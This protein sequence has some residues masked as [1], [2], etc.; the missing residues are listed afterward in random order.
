LPGLGEL[1]SRKIDSTAA[2]HQSEIENLWIMPAGDLLPN[3]AELLARSDMGEIVRHLGEKF[4]R[5]VIDT[6]PVTAVSDTLLLLEHAEAICLVAHGGKTPR[7]WIL[8]ALKLI[9]EAGSRPVGVI[10]NQM[11]MRMAG[12]YS[13]Y[14]GKYGE[15]EVYGSNGRYKGTRAGDEPEVAGAAPRF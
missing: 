6:A 3:P 2:I 1:L 7:K 13:Y 10:L 8:R 14:P 4:Q 11:P 15:P 9:A 12:A 5:I